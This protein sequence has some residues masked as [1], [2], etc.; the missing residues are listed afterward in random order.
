MSGHVILEIDVDLVDTAALE[1]HY[2][3]THLARTGRYPNQCD[4]IVDAL[5]LLFE[6]AVCDTP[7][8]VLSTMHGERPV[9]GYGRAE[10]PP[11]TAAE[12][13]EWIAEDE[14]N[15]DR[16]VREARGEYDGAVA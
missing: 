7:G 8:I 16:D 11:P 2:G 5:M 14:A 15:D 12:L 4:G 9:F 1:R 10:E 3:R 13:R 6:W